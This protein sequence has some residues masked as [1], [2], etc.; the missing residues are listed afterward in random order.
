MIFSDRLAI[1]T[2]SLISPP[3]LVIIVLHS[4]VD[5]NL[6]AKKLLIVV[7]NIEISGAKRIKKKKVRKKNKYFANVFKVF[8]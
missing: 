1:P 5:T 6:S 7:H 3:T 4:L 8:H 2:T